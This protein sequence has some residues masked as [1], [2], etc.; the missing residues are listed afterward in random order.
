MNPFDFPGPQFLVFY[1]LLGVLVVV[2]VAI[3][4]RMAESGAVPKL[5]FS[6][7]YLL[8]YLRGGKNEALRVATVSLIDRGLLSAKDDTVET[9]TNVSP[10][11]VQRPIEK[12]LLQKFRQYHHATV[13]FGDPVLAASCSA[14]EQTLTRLSLLPD[15]D[16][17]RARWRRFFFALALLDGVAL[18]KIVIALNR[19]RQNVFFLLMLAVVFTL[20]V[21]QVSLPFR[22]TRGNALLAD[23]RT[24]FAALK[25]RATSLRSGGASSE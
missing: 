25:K 20:V 21:A 12:A 13:I 4:R 5:D 19:G 3:F 15:A 2:T 9:R 17:K 24:L 10:D 16:T 1:S 7:P 8:A 6:D 23:A 18:L 11:H 22:T 14:Y